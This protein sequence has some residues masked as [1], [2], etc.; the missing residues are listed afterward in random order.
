MSGGVID[1]VFQVFAGLE[2]GNFLSRHFDFF[3]GLGLR[4]TRP[5]RSRVR[6]LPK[7]RISIF[8]PFCKA[9]MM[10]S[11]MVSTIVSDSLRGSSVTF[12]TSSIRSALV[13]VDVLCLVISLC[14]VAQSR[15]G[16]PKLSRPL[17]L[18]GARCRVGDYKGL[19]YRR[20]APLPIIKMTH[21]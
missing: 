15:N 18:P 14:L 10:L 21:G 4:P 17:H 1:K 20:I 7:P 11:N 8:S 13:S 16:L 6:K 9:P 3:S 12:K 5:R 2:I 19:A